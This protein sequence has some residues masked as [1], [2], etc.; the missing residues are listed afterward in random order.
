MYPGRKRPS[1]HP[2]S[3]GAQHLP[4][5][6]QSLQPLGR[7]LCWQ[8]ADPFQVLPPNLG[9]AVLSLLPRTDILA[10]GCCCRRGRVT[11]EAALAAR[12]AAGEARLQSQDDD[13]VGYTTGNAAAAGGWIGDDE[14]SCPICLAEVAAA[15]NS[16][17]VKLQ[18]GHRY[19][20]AAASKAGSHE[21]R[22]AQYAA[23]MLVRTLER[24]LSACLKL[25]AWR[26]KGSGERT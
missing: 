19:T 18:C 16:G 26:H 2:Q 9:A 12:A 5:Q 17:V 14:E 11:A 24:A 3:R 8:R 4:P 15:G 13:E 1:Q 6:A 10:T 25:R 7:Q 20:T 22:L 23:V 21:T